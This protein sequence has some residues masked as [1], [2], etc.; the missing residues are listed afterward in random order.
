MKETKAGETELQCH[1]LRAF[2]HA[3]VAGIGVHLGLSAEQQG[4]SL[5]EVG[6]VRRR[7]DDRVHEFAVPVYADAGFQSEIQR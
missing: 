5:G 1:D 4:D 6:D 2:L 7:D 3:G